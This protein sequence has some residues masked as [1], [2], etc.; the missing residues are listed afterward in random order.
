MAENPD[1]IKIIPQ[2][3]EK[4]KAVYTDHF[5]FMDTLQFL[6]ASLAKLFDNLKSQG[7]DNLRGG[8]GGG[9]KLF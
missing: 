6:P 1:D 5:I 8:G 9:G 3:L 7:S 4:F 2:N